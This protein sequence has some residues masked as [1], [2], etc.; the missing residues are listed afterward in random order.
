VN[1]DF[2]F[3]PPDNQDFFVPD[4]STSRVNVSTNMFLVREGVRFFIFS[5]GS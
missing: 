5:A 1:L 2:I 4:R 3:S